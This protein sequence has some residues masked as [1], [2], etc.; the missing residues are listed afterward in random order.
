LIEEEVSEFGDG[1]VVAKMAT[2]DATLLL[3]YLYKNSDEIMSNADPLHEQFA[4]GLM[5]E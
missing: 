5:I 2:R 1:D 3:S 4:R